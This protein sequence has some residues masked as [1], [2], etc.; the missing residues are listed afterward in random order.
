MLAW[1]EFSPG[2]VWLWLIWG[3]LQER[4]TLEGESEGNWS[5]VWSTISGLL[6]LLNPPYSVCYIRWDYLRPMPIS[7]FGDMNPASSRADPLIDSFFLCWALFSGSSIGVFFVLVACMR[8][9]RF[10][11]ELFYYSMP[12]FDIITCLARLLLVAWIADGVIVALF[13]PI[14]YFIAEIRFLAKLSGVFSAVCGYPRSLA[15][16]FFWISDWA[17]FFGFWIGASSR[18]AF[19]CD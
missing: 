18:R 6:I 5:G 15:F 14:D 13:P 19:S 10:S 9:K 16:N 3:L 1:P 12:W 17:C 8:L 4:K 11:V 2:L 7:S